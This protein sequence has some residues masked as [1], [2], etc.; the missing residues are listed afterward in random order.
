MNLTLNT[1]NLL[2]LLR[3]FLTPVVVLLVIYDNILAAAVVF[4]FAATT[5]VLDGLVAR[6][7]AQKTDFGTFI[8]PLADKALLV[9]TFLVLTFKAMIPLWLCIIVLLRELVIMVLIRMLWSADR[10]VEIKPSLT[11]KVTTFFQII[12][13]IYVMVTA[14]SVT[15]VFY[16]V[17]GATGLVTLF[18]GFDYLWREIKSQIDRGS[19][20]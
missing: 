15:V 2:T 3:F 16:L 19:R 8:D 12:T 11:G 6:W 13:I 1:A 10:K 17:V 5:D 18:S 7:F 20:A 4:A 14:D 9:S